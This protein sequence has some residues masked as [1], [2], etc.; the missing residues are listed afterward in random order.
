M[1]KRM[2]PRSITT[3]RRT[4]PS[5]A[6]RLRPASVGSSLRKVGVRCDHRR[7]PARLGGHADGLAQ[8]VRPEVELMVAEGGGVVA[9]AGHELQFAAGL[10]GCGGERGPHAVVTR[11]KHQHRALTLACGLP[12]RDQRGQ[13]RV[14]AAGRVIVECERRVVRGGRHAD[15][16]RVQV[17][18]VQDGESLLAGCCGGQC[19]RQAERRADGGG[20]GQELAAGECFHGL[21]QVVIFIT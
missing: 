19:A 7:H 12:L 10:A 15:E 3:W 20:R 14:P 13:T 8:A 18:R 9:H 5:L 16:V 11:V 6:S 21:V 2:P 1:P 17:V 4:T